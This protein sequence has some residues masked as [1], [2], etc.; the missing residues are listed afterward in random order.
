MSKN[1][2]IIFSDAEAEVNLVGYRLF[3]FP[4]E[5]ESVFRQVCFLAGW[6]L[7]FL[8]VYFQALEL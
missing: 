7:E 8:G 4:A 1:G 3:Y 6:V 5:R 2:L